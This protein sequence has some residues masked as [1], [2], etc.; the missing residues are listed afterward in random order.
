VIQSEDSATFPLFDVQNTDQIRP[1]NLDCMVATVPLR[2]SQREQVVLNIQNATPGQS[3]I[4]SVK[5]VP[6]AL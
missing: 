3:F 4:L 5:Y 1:Y 6:Q 2:R